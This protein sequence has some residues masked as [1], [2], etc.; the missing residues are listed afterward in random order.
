MEDLY[1]GKV[2]GNKKLSVRV[3]CLDKARQVG[4]IWRWPK[5]ADVMNYSVDVV[6]HIVTP[7]VIDMHPKC[8][9]LYYVKELLNKLCLSN[10]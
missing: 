8:G 6:Q 3:S 5:K 9:N 2:I 4:S 10:T 1:P 7:K